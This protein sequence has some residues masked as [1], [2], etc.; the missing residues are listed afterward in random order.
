MVLFTTDQLAKVEGYL[1]NDQTA[2]VL[3]V[4]EG[5]VADMQAYIDEN[6]VTTDDVQWFSFSSPFEKLTYRRV[7]NDPRTLMDAPV[8]FDR[9]YAD[10]AFCL[11]RQNDLEKAAEQLKQAVRWNPMDCTHRLDLAAVLA[12]L[13][14]Y[15]EHLKLS[16]SVFARASRSSHLVRA[17]L[18]FA[19]YFEQCGQFE[20]AA[21]CVKCAARLAPEDKR[22]VNAASKLAV[23]H[24]C[25]AAA[26]A[27]ELTESL[28][29]AQGIPEG[30]NVEVVLSALLLADLSAAQG[31]M[32]T[33]QD[34]VQVSVDLVGQKK[35]MALAEIVRE[36]G[37][38]NFPEET[39][40]YSSTN[41]YASP[42]AQATL[43]AASRA[44]AAG[45]AS[46]TR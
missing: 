16:Y 37:E 40:G 10:F 42:A 46:A 38:E 5:L 30:A 27:D 29:E 13:G 11:I 45:G 36:Q 8:P 9:A 31:D 39:E 6:C 17:Y 15:E 14:D 44:A 22:V 34:M 24:Q 43:E 19:D 25:D 12:H 20:T 26:Q 7:E 41:E 1:A 32:R 3:P 33:C 28:L 4:L 2:E 21:A 35:A 23:E 18:N